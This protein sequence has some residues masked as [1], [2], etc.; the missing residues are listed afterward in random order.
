[1]QE[2]YWQAGIIRLDSSAAGPRRSIGRCGRQEVGSGWVR[3]GEWDYIARGWGDLPQL[4][5]HV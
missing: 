1:M 5:C 3:D 4:G 2:V